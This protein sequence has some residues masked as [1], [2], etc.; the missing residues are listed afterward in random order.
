MRAQ[1]KKQ[2]LVQPEECEAVHSSMME[3]MDWVGLTER[4]SNETLPLL[5]RLLDLPPGFAFE[6]HKV[7]KE[8]GEYFGID[9]VTYSAIETI[10]QRSSLDNWLYLSAKQN[11]PSSMWAS[12]FHRFSLIGESHPFENDKTN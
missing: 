8:A 12:S 7:T 1:V 9:N 2:I 6:K 11:F 4:L 5:S 3:L 10:L